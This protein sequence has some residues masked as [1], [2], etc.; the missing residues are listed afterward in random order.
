MSQASIEILL[1][2]FL[3]L[4][5]VVVQAA[6]AARHRSLVEASAGTSAPP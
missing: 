4:K 5:R 2:Y 1:R 6:I 3:R